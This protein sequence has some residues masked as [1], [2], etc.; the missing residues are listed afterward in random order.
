MAGRMARLDYFVSTIGVS[1]AAGL[2]GGILETMGAGPVL[3]VRA[4]VVLGLLGLTSL[5]G[6]WRLHD[7]NRSGWWVLLTW[8]PLAGQAIYIF[9]VFRRGTMGVNRY[10]HDPLQPEGHT[11][12]SKRECSACKAEYFLSDYDQRSQ[13]W[14]CAACGSLLPRA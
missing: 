10:G 3:V 1:I 9:L 11:V 2:W 5:F 4:A 14:K 6:I 12:G 8:L 7:I 13:Q